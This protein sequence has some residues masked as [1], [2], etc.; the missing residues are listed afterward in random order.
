MYIFYM[1]I[2]MYIYIYIYIYIYTCIYIY[3]YM[4]EQG[5][6]YY[7]TNPNKS[8]SGLVINL[9]IVQTSFNS[10]EFCYLTVNLVNTYMYMYIYIYI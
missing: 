1:Y 9:Y 3:V 6:A 10:E 2:H 4:L 8:G 7:V 5:K